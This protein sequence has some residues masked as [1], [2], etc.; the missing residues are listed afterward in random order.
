MGMS[1][2]MTGP[3]SSLMSTGLGQ[4]PSSEAHIGV[5][6]FT[7]SAVIVG[8]NGFFSRWFTGRWVA[9]FCALAFIAGATVIWTAQSWPQLL[10]GYGLIGLGNGGNSFWYNAEIARKFRDRGVGAWLSALNGFWAVGAMTGP[11]MVGQSN[12]AWHWPVQLIWGL[13]FFPAVVAWF[14]PAPPVNEAKDEAREPLPRK[15]YGLM[16]LLGLYVGVEVTTL[17]FMSRHLMGMH[18]LKLAAASTIASTLWFAFMIARF[19]CGPLSMRVHPSRIVVASACLAVVGA[20]LISQ[21]GLGWVGYIVLGLAMGPVFPSVIQ[22]GTCL[23]H[24]PHRSTAIMVLGP[25]ITGVTFP[26]L[27]AAGMGTHY[28]ILP[29]LILIVHGAIAVGASVLGSSRAILAN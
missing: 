13:A 25:C 28:S 9:R 6:L 26:A 15:T 4:A 29:W 1:V 14:V 5:A 3:I 18:G 21:P 19:C 2:T 23:G 11:L 22:W 16:V 27:V 10:V 8:L 20:L 7:G 24:A 12:G 17:T